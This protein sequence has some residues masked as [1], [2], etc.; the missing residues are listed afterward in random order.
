M[1]LTAREAEITLRL[2]EGLTDPEIARALGISTHTVR[3]HVER[4]FLKLGIRSRKA[5]G[6]FL[7]KLSRRTPF[8]R[9]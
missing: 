2:A 1:G 9:E 5:L 7:L 3:H 8:R 6:L 4:I